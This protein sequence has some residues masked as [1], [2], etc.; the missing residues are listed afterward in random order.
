MLLVTPMQKV[1]RLW[2][3]LLVGNAMTMQQSFCLAQPTTNP[4]YI[5]TAPP[6]ADSAL[7]NLYASI[8]EE[9]ATMLRQVV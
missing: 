9:I 4:P 7:A 6:T 8:R 2:P 1:L 5:Q 3:S